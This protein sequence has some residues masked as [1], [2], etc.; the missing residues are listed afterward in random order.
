MIV[1]PYFYMPEMDDNQRLKVKR[2]LKNEVPDVILHRFAYDYVFQVL[3]KRITEN[4]ETSG[5]ITYALGVLAKYLEGNASVEALE[6]LH[7]GLMETLLWDNDEGHVSLV[8][9]ALRGPLTGAKQAFAHA[10][11]YYGWCDWYVDLE[12]DERDGAMVLQIK[13]TLDIPI[14]TAI[15]LMR[16]YWRYFRQSRSTLVNLLRNRRTDQLA[17]IQQVPPWQTETEDGLFSE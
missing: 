7:I 15:E 11:Y 10:Y 14:H 6:Y 17:A 1:K 13:S 12:R 4:K 9:A 8:A 16:R 3:Q 2:F 5:M